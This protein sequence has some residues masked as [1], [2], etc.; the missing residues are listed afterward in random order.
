MTC[1]SKW[2]IVEGLLTALAQAAVPA[3]AQ[4]NSPTLLSQ[5][6]LVVN[7]TGQPVPTAPQGTT[8]V[9]GTVNVGN[10]PH[11][12]V[13]NTPSVNVANT[14]TVMLESGASVNVTSPLDGQSNP[15]P[16]ATLEAVQVYGITCGI[17]FSGSNLG[18]CEF[19]AVPQGKQLIVQEF[20]ANGQVETGNRPLSLQLLNTITSGNYFPYTFLVNADGLDFLATHQETRVYLEAGS[21]PA[22]SVQLAQFSIG[23]YDCDISGFLVDVPFGSATIAAVPTQRKHPALPFGRH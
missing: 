10:T 4:Q 1:K 14:P 16:L 21:I 17:G 13:A 5:K 18:F 6:V 2:M 8:K 15:R 23:N 7:G 12:T 22:C 9:D 3:V 19:T 11:V 20:D